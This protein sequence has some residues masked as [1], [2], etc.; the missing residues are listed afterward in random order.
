MINTKNKK[1]ELIDYGGDGRSLMLSD[2]YY[3]FLLG[4]SFD[5]SEEAEDFR[6]DN[7]IPEEDFYSTLIETISDISI[8]VQREISHMAKYI[9]NNH[10]E[11]RIAIDDYSGDI[12]DSFVT[13]EYFIVNASENM[14]QKYKPAKC[15]YDNK[16]IKQ[17]IEHIYVIVIGGAECTVYFGEYE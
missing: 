10:K 15:L 5:K 9:C 16:I 17:Y 7:D 6:L 12:Y 14:I 3:Q 13:N 1:Y 11:A 8:D 2:E 4:Y